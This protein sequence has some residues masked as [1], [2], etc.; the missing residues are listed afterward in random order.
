MFKQKNKLNSEKSKKSCKAKKRRNCYIL[1]CLYY[2]GNNAITLKNNIREYDVKWTKDCYLTHHWWHS[3]YYTLGARNCFW[4][5]SSGS[6]C[7]SLKPLRSYRI[8]QNENS[9]IVE[10][11]GLEITF[12]F[13]ILNLILILLSIPAVCSSQLWVW[14][15]HTLT[16]MRH[17]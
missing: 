4:Y 10:L 8:V 2:K 7:G 15:L 13:L 1:K 16:E 11:V 17:Y 14:Q 3:Y 6:L 9:K 5:S 12:E